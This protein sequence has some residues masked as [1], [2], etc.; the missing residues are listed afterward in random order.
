MRRKMDD[1][2]FGHN[3][4]DHMKYVY[5]ASVL[6]D[7][8]REK[9]IEYRAGIQNDLSVFKLAAEQY[10]KQHGWAIREDDHCYAIVCPSC[11]KNT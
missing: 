10:I 3:M 8:C 6:C 11:K 4:Q 9:K 7:C 1:S 5:T 2:G